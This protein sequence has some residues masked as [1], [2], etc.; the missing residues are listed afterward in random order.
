MRGRL[1]RGGG[2][3]S[4]TVTAAREHSG[5]LLLSLDGVGDRNTA[6]DLRGTLFLVDSSDVD[7]GSDPDEFY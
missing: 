6:D 1:P 5:R 7:S 3:K 2:E 4:F